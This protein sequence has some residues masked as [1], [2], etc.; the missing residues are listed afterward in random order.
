MG[1]HIVTV[2]A[3]NAFEP[4]NGRQH[5]TKNLSENAMSP[6]CLS[7]QRGNSVPETFQLHIQALDKPARSF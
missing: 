2:V 1:N 4:S 3:E 6:K 5:P 7:S